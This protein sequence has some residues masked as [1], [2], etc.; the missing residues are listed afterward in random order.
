VSSSYS[1]TNNSTAYQTASGAFF[2]SKA[3]GAKVRGRGEGVVRTPTSQNPSSS[4]MDLELVVHRMS[5][6]DQAY[7][8]T[9]LDKINLKL[10]QVGYQT[11]PC[12][13]DL[14]SKLPNIY[15]NAEWDDKYYDINTSM[16][17][18]HNDLFVQVVVLWF[19]PNDHGVE[20][21]RVYPC[22]FV[23][24][25]LPIIAGLKLLNDQN[26]GTTLYD[27]NMLNVFN[28]ANMNLSPLLENIGIISFSPTLTA[29]GFPLAYYDSSVCGALKGEIKTGESGGV[30][31][32]NHVNLKQ[33]GFR[34]IT[35]G[36]NGV[37]NVNLNMFRLIF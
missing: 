4:E 28:P 30:A 27:W 17:E 8:N 34:I 37:A 19:M 12:I 23:D 13:R 35:I 31:L 6:I 7:Y 20:N 2:P 25:E 33:G 18:I 9:L 32:S 29:N 24:H 11:L 3:T 1:F 5:I 16:F 10:L 22:H 26:Q 21:M 36:V 15:I 14:L